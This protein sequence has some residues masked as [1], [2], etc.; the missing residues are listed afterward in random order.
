MVH[1]AC[2][3]ETKKCCK[4]YGET[5]CILWEINR[6]QGVIHIHELEL[7]TVP[8]RT[9]SKLFFAKQIKNLRVDRV[10]TLS[11]S[12]SLSL[13]FSLSTFDLFDPPNTFVQSCRSIGNK[14]VLSIHASFA[15]KLAISSSPNQS[16]QRVL[17]I[18]PT[19][20]I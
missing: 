12:L 16:N 8:T 7:H 3:L 13:S 10:C 4:V 2:G 9:H 1:E 17:A 15:S 6:L 14:S 11:L 5:Q 20:I 18:I 19:Y